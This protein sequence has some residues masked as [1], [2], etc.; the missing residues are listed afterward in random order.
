MVTVLWSAAH[1]MHYRFLN[2]SKIITSEKYAQQI[3]EI[4]R[5]LQC[6]LSALINRKDPILLHDNA[7]LHIPQPGLQKLNKLGYKFC[8][9]HYIHLTDYHFFKHLGNFLQ[10]K[11]FHNQ[12]EAENAFQEFFN[13]KAWI[14]MLHE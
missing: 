1:L 8:F 3:D 12:Q 10:G 7:Q 13:P 14:F 5:K 6:V 11:C 9:I 4:H 2:P